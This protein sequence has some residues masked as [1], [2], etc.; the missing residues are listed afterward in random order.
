MTSNESFLQWDPAQVSSYINLILPD[1]SGAGTAFLDN[2]IEGSLL[3][4]LTTDH[5]REIGFALLHTRLLI[6]KSF[7][8]LITNQYQKNPP[9]SLNDPEY[10]LNNVN[11]NNNYISLESLTLSTILVQDMFKKVSLL[12]HVQQQVQLQQIEGSPISPSRNEYKKLQDNFT[13]LKSDLNPVIRLLKDSKP[14]PTPTLDPGPI[15][16]DSPTFSLASVQSEASYWTDT[17]TNQG[18]RSSST[19][20]NEPTL[21]NPVMVNPTSGS[22]TRGSSNSTSPKYLNRFSSGSALLLG[23]PGTGKI[24]QQSVPKL[25]ETRGQAEFI[26]PKVIPSKN[27]MDET[28]ATT[29]SVSVTRPRLTAVKSSGSLGAPA[30]S[31]SSVPMN[32][33]QKPS[34]KLHV[35]TPTFSNKDDGSPKISQLL[36][37]Q[38]HQQ[39]Q[40]AVLTPTQ[41]PHPQ[42]L[43]P[44]K[45]LRASTEDSCVKILQQAMKRHHIPR[46]DWSKYVL[47]ICYG[48]KER[49]LKLE[50]KP[51]IIFKELQEL[52]KHPAIMLR[53]LANDIENEVGTEQYQNSRIGDD[54]PGGTL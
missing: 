43:E 53:Q 50:E 39:Q 32:N 48:D 41:A 13:K 14:L 25:A 12:I 30:L 44:L 36:Q 47:V 51:V 29:A 9:Q 4:F 45:Q 16:A 27:S 33:H 23:N 22:N 8:D 6:K 5:L 35:S 17:E 21:L 40:Q 42:S 7:S 19:P 1:Q 38:Q 26:L 46:D 54:I 20:N 34:L 37:F 15:S 2:N 28:T 24:I 49:I 11:I 10:K 18:N 52:G 3:P 31:T